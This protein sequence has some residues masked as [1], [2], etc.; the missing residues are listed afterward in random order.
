MSNTSGT[1]NSVSEPVIQK[2]FN[3]PSITF[4]IV[5]IALIA[6]LF[7]FGII[8]WI[9]AAIAA[10]IVLVIAGSIKI[11]DQWEKAVV[12]RMGKFHGLRGPGLFFIIPIIDRIDKYI[13]QRVRVTDF[14]AE[15][16][17]TK[18]TVPVDVDLVLFELL[19]NIYAK[20]R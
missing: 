19:K 5:F 9:I 20:F 10:V 3:L 14:N 1:N 18:D 11:A 17:L 16:T 8:H 15:K 2:N 4:F 6:I 12:L 13:D 7:Y